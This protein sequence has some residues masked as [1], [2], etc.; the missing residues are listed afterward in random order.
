[1]TLKSEQIPLLIAEDLNPPKSAKATKIDNLVQIGHG[2]SLGQ[3]NMIVAQTGMA[4][5][6]K[7]GR[8]VS[9]QDNAAFLDIF[10]LKMASFSHQGLERTNP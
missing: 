7:T 9:W 8:Y 10:V 3:H 1:M 6:A 2:A 4:G 5:S